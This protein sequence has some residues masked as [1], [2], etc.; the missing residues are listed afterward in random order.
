MEMAKPISVAKLRRARAAWAFDLGPVP[1]VLITITLVSMTSLLYLNQASAVAAT[2]YDINS[3]ADQRG[4]L[5]RQQQ[6]LLVALAERQSLANIE[7]AATAKLGMVPAPPPYYVR[8]TPAPLD[9]DGALQRALEDA[10]HQPRDW[11][12]RLAVMLRLTL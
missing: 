2:G 8:I 9:V 12:E 5:E 10:K 1:L 4:R 6:Q 3:A 11:R 7:K